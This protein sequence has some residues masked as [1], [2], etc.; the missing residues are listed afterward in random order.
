MCKYN[1]FIF[2]AIIDF[3]YVFGY[4]LSVFFKNKSH[5]V[6]KYLVKRNQFVQKNEIIKE[7]RQ[8]VW[9]FIKYRYMFESREVQIPNDM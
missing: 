1:L 5:D 2:S 9:K 6:N 3:C 4:Y 7:I 8:I